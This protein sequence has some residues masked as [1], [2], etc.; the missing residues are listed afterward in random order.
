METR[1]K[2]IFPILLSGGAGARLWPMSRESYPKQLL[3]LAGDLTLLQLAA[4]RVS[5]TEVFE[6]PIVVANVDHRFVVAEQL[7]ALRKAAPTIVLEPLSR[8]SAAAAAVGAELAL[9]QDTDALILLLPVDHIGR[10]HHRF[11]ADI[12]AAVPAALDGQIVLFGA[13]AQSSSAE[14]GCIRH[15]VP[16]ADTACAF[17][18]EAFAERPD[19]DEART[20]LEEGRG[21]W[22]SGIV[23]A[24]AATVLAGLRRH[25]P[26]VADCASRS[27]ASAHR[28]LDFL[29]LDGAALE[30]CPPL[31]LDRALLEAADRVC[32]LEAGFDWTDVSSWSTLWDIAAKSPAGNVVEGEAFA[33]DSRDCY[34]RS[35]GP[36]V[37]ALG[38]ENL[39]VVAT[40]DAV[41]VID[42]ARSHEAPRLIETLR[43][44]G[45]EAATQTRWVHRPWGSYEGVLNGQGFQ[46]KQITVAPGRKLSLQKH[47]HR[48]EHWIVVG[49][50]ALATIDGVEHEVRRNESV[51][52][53]LGAVHRLANPGE[54]PLILIEVQSGDYLGEDDIVRLEDDYAR[55][56]AAP[57]RPALT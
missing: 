49:G 6:P 30:A 21:L 7:H 16:L 42:K 48:A 50:V 1:R 29:R 57:S 47:F 13:R 55:A 56:E 20:W 9:A 10:D 31:S 5:D 12:S 37:A 36:V 54:T 40:T 23:L 2:R 17:E 11:Q 43:E 18:V 26:E 8:G 53:P 28:D 22:N 3:P 34:I 35:D 46:V 19:P 32:V 52:I 15:G 45:R 41:L 14:L 24:S 51:F 44:A 4:T 25:A 39:I 27:L 38:V 33:L